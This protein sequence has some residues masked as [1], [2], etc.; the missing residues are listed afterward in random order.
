MGYK[1]E[2]MHDSM[3]GLKYEE[4]MTICGLWATKTAQLEYILSP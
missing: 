1:W 3:M 4:L 2:E